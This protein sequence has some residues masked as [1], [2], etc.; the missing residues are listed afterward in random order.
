[1]IGR[2]TQKSLAQKLAI[3]PGHDVAVVNDPPTAADIVSTLRSEAAIGDDVG[4][5]QAVLL[6]VADRAELARFW[7]SIGSS[8]RTD[9]VLWIAYPKR[10]SSVRTDLS[11][12]HGWEPIID[13]GLDTVSQVSLDETWSALRF[14]RDPALRKA[15]AARGRPAPGHRPDA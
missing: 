2:M 5:A 10:T 8:V 7:P 13:S 15:R 11:R 9:A 4:S 12:D 6:F 3:K 1:M 14:R